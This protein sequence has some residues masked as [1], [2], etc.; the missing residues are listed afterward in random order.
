MNH[1]PNAEEIAVELQRM[2]D[3][4][5]LN[6]PTEVFPTLPSTNLYAKE[7]AKKGADRALIV[8][9]AQTAGR[10]RM[11]RSFYSPSGVGVY[12]SILHA[13]DIA[14]ADAVSVTC[15][16]AVAVMRAIRSVCGVQT[17]IKW[18]NDLYYLGKKV[19]GI[20][21]EAVRD[22]NVSSQHALIVGIGINLRSATFP[23]E[24]A[25]IAGT[26][27]ADSVDPSDLIAAVVDELSAFLEDPTN[28]E[29]LEDYRR[30]SCVIGKEITWRCGDAVYTG[31]ALDIDGDGALIV[32]NEAGETVSLNT[33]EISV[34]L[35]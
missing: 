14:L 21:T 2:L 19:C 25:E 12:F 1:A 4:Q 9:L 23:S 5:I 10:G 13:V 35:R 26:L 33:G 18:V 7:L 30:H 8:A 27:G 34:R 17:K 6:Y 22:P 32:Q 28:R 24:L 3:E 11:E 29:W 15:A 16:A 31:R 20:L